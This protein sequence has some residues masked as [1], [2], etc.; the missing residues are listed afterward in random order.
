MLYKSAS[1]IAYVLSPGFKKPESLGP[2]SNCNSLFAARLSKISNEILSSKYYITFNSGKYVSFIITFV[3]SSK[4]SIDDF[5]IQRKRK[6]EKIGHQKLL[7]KVTKVYFSNLLCMIPSK[8][9]TMTTFNICYIDVIMVKDEL[10][11][12]L[13]KKMIMN[14]VLTCEV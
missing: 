14:H 10:D 9:R 12:Q 8:L 5:K 1:A 11:G 13:H 2:P 7:L 4:T 3:K 6:K